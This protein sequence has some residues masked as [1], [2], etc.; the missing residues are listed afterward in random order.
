MIGCDG[1]ISTASSRSDGIAAFAIELGP[2]HA[3]EFEFKNH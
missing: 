1:P 3:R 2:F